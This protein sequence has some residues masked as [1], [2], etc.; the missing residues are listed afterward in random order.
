MV[1]K[2]RKRRKRSARDGTLGIP[3][4]PRVKMLRGIPSDTPMLDGVRVSKLLPDE[5]SPSWDDAVKVYEDRG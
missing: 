5:T 3:G 4:A 2:R 1:G